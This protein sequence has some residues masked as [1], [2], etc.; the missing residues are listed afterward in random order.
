MFQRFTRP[1]ALAAAAA[2]VSSRTFASAKMPNQP[3]RRFSFFATSAIIGI[4][5]FFHSRFS[6]LLQI[7]TL[8]SPCFAEQCCSPN[9]DSVAA[10]HDFAASYSTTGDMNASKQKLRDASLLST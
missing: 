5:W 2:A 9:L 8:F 3:A 4:S 1:A 7:A 6:A 10:L